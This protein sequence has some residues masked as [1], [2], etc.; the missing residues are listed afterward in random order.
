[1]KSLLITVNIIL[2][3]LVVWSAAKQF[4]G[5]TGG[6]KVEYSVKKPAPKKAQPPAKVKKEEK[7][8]AKAKDQIA[9]LI[10]ENIFNQDRCPNANMP[11]GRNARVELSLVGTFTVGTCVGAIILQKT[12]ANNNR[13][14]FMGGFPG[15]GFPGGG[16][17]MGIGSNAGNR[18]GNTNNRGGW[19]GGRPGGGPGGNIRTAQGISNINTQA[20]V[21]Y[22]QYVR[23]GETLSN[24]YTLTEVN[25]GKVTLKRGSDKLEL[26]LLDASKNAPQTANRQNQRINRGAQF[27]QMIQ[28]MQQMQFMQN[29]QMMRM[30]RGNNQQQGGGNGGVN[31]N[32][33]NR[34]GGRAGMGGSTRNRN[35]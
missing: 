9:S 18:G 17:Q 14:G 11:G 28:G 15:G 32:N 5:F 4:G 29:M 26:E 1:M 13:W 19:R 20:P 35:R 33:N 22:K 3:A 30:M 25:A 6:S 21:V 12:S 10:E 2:A 16:R 24:G 34:T 23:L 27:M 31:N 8:P 7:A